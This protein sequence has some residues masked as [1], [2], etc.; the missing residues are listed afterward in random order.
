MV[1]VWVAVGRLCRCCEHALGNCI[2]SG[3][4]DRWGGGYCL[5]GL[6]GEGGEAISRLVFTW[7]VMGKAWKCECEVGV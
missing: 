1:G 6:C 7:G 2:S 3:E 4:W 5:R